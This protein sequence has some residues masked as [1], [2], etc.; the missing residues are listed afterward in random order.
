MQQPEDQKPRFIAH[1]SSLDLLIERGVGL[2]G[3]LGPYLVSGIRMGLLALRLLDCSGYSDI[4]AESDAGSTPPLSCLTDGIQ[5]GCGC[6]P[7][8]GNLRVT[9]WRRPRVWFA[10]SGGRTVTIELR[11]EVMA[12]FRERSLEQASEYVKTLP[13][14]ELLLWNQPSS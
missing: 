12:S 8:K 10:D 9:D 5:I 7:G 14:E 2:H 1:E 11:P 6:T 4:T 13:V 3:H